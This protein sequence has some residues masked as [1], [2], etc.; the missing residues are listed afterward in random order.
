MVDDRYLSLFAA[1]LVGLP[2]AMPEEAADA[3]FMSLTPANLSA[4]APLQSTA[5]A[6]LPYD[7]D[8]GV[9]TISIVGQTVDRPTWISDVLGL[10]SYRRVST[11]LRAAIADPQVRGV[12]LDFDSPGGDFS[13]AAELAA[14]VRQASAR[15]PVVAHVDA[16]AASA[17]YVVAAGAQRII[18]TPSATVGSI[19][20]VWLHL[21]RSAAM[22]KSGVKPTILHAGAAKADGNSLHPLAPEAEKR[23]RARLGDSYQVLLN[24]IGAHRPKL[25][26]A[27]ARATEAALYLGEKAVAA[28]LA[29]AVGDRALARSYLFSPP[30]SSPPAALARPSPASVSAPSLAQGATPMPAV[31]FGLPAPPSGYFYSSAALIKAAKREQRRAAANAVSARQRGAQSADDSWREVLAAGGALAPAAAAAAAEPPATA[32]DGWSEIINKMR[33]ASPAGVCFR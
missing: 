31:A 1:K 22:A 14:E 29:D 18:V 2:L 28:G 32:D 20:V 19:G 17:A 16:L 30:A 13:G 9:A 25:G 3:A 33:S 6:A 7:L 11:A 12:I 5:G 4:L 8:R 23:I 27:G 15:K 10:S 26:A 24:S 21:D